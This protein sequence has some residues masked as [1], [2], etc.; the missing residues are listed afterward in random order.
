MNVATS[1]MKEKPQH[2]KGGAEVTNA[3]RAGITHF[4]LSEEQGSQKQV[5]PRGKRKKA[6]GPATSVGTTRGQRASRRKGHDVAMEGGGVNFTAK[7]TKGGKTGG[8]RAGL[9]SSRKA[10]KDKRN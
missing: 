10:S 8:S 1:V 7:G 2:L 5:P 4:S 9:T 6:S 3:R